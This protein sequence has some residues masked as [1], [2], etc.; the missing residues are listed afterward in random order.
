MFYMIKQVLNCVLDGGGT[1][2]CTVRVC[3]LRQS[4]DPDM[5]VDVEHG[6][7]KRDHT[8]CQAHGPSS[9]CHC[10]ITAF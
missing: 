4:A 2:S 9:V 1:P 3:A 6:G 8:S 10:P 7:W 5:S